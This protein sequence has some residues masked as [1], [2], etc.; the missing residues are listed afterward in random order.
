MNMNERYIFFEEYLGKIK[1]SGGINLV[2]E[3]SVAVDKRFISKGEAIIIQD[4]SNRNNIFLGIA[5]DEGI[6]IKGK[7]RIDLFSGY[8]LSAE[9]KAAKLNKKIFT[10][11][12]VPKIYINRR[13]F[14]KNIGDKWFKRIS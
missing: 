12:V 10:R 8:G 3:I 14:E 13:N 7:S 6:A 4:I 2:P 9:K 1:G 11:K 5:H